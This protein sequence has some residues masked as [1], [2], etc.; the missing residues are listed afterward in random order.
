MKTLASMVFA[1]TILS[2]LVSQAQIGPKVTCTALDKTEVISVDF[3]NSANA[4]MT[5]SDNSGQSLTIPARVYDQASGKASFSDS[6]GGL[7]GLHVTEVQGV[8]TATSNS[9]GMGPEGHYT[10]ENK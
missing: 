5:I 2:A 7:I 4:T 10:C 9:I 1:G 6:Q 8:L 3:T